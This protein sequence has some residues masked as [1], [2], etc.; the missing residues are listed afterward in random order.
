MTAPRVVAGRYVACAWHRV[1]RGPVVA[2]VGHAVR[3]GLSCGRELSERDTALS[4]CS[5]VI[6][7]RRQMP[8]PRE[9]V[10]AGDPRTRSRWQGR[11]YACGFGNQKAEPGCIRP[12]PQYCEASRLSS[13]LEGSPQRAQ[14]G[15]PPPSTACSPV[16]R[17]TMGAVCERRSAR[18]AGGGGPEA[19][20]AQPPAPPAPR[21]AGLIRKAAFAPMG[22]LFLQRKS[23]S[24]PKVRSQ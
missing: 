24:R 1:N 5:E 3:P 22:P 20:P 2:P 16:N 18:L 4:G 21:S 10:L 12:G 13:T 8:R 6:A 17:A 15:W 19:A 7:E 14:C 11:P 9:A 23:L